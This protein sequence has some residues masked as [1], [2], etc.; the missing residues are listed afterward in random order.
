[1]KPRILVIDDESAIRDSLRMILEYE[2]YEVQGA[3][4]GQDG[5]TLVDRDPPELVFLDIKMAGMDAR[6]PLRL[7]PRISDRG[8]DES[9]LRR[10]GSQA[11]HPGLQ[12]LLSNRLGC[13]DRSRQRGIGVIPNKVFG[14]LDCGP[15]QL[16]FT[17]NSDTPYGPMLLDLGIGPLVVEL[18]PGPLIVCSMDVNQRWVADMGLPG[19]DA[20]KGGKHLLLPPDYTA[21]CLV[22]A[23]RPS[24]EQ[25]PPDR[26]RPVPAGEWR[27]AGGQGAAEDDQGLSVSEDARLAGTAVA[28]RHRQNAGHDAAGVGGQH[29]VLGSVGQDR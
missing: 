15:E 11:R 25:Q 28:R 7:R 23:I 18:A 13:G 8:H 16:V 20:G 1:M 9:V 17:A 6:E 2:G 4:T 22:R 14:I 5:L 3:A 10:C 27:R 26:R 24:R 19:P 21:R 29:P 12:I